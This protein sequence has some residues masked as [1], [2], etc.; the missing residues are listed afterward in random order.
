MRPKHLEDCLTVE[1]KRN[2]NQT[3]MMEIHYTNSTPGGSFN[4][5]AVV[6]KEINMI[7]N[8]LWEALN[9][10]CSLSTSSGC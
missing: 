2:S 6:H 4:L 8:R 5:A 1:K 7:L 3:Y 9:D 10:T